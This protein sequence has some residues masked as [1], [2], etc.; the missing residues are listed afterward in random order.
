[1]VAVPTATLSTNPT[2]IIAGQATTLTWS[3][4]SGTSCTLNGTHG[5]NDNG[6]WSQSSLSSSGS[7]SITPYPSSQSAYVAQYNV[8]CSGYGLSGSATA[9]V[10][11]SPAS[12]T[13]VPVVTNVTAAGANPT[14]GGA[15]FVESSGL[16][17]FD[18]SS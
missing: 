12:V 16:T 2:T 17:R 11:V 4:T 3:S 5:Y 14:P 7:K 15:A 18:Y 9:Y 6:P 10:T 1:M 8:V 13:P